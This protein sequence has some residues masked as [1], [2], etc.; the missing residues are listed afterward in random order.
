MNDNIITS[1]EELLKKG[2]QQNF[3]LKEKKL[4]GNLLEISIIRI[5]M[6]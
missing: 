3:Y 5:Q 1:C 4:I 2:S 6:K